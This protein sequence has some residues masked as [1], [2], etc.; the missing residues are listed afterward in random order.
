MSA[1]DRRACSGAS[2]SGPKS[3]YL[4]RG[5]SCI[6]T[7]FGL[8]IVG[9]RFQRLHLPETQLYRCRRAGRGR[10]TRVSHAATANGVFGT[11]RPLLGDAVGACL[12]RQVF[13]ECPGASRAA[14]AH[15]SL[16]RQ[17]ASARR[18]GLLPGDRCHDLP[19]IDHQAQ[20]ALRAAR[21]SPPPASASSETVPAG[22]ITASGKG[23]LGRVVGL[24]HRRAVE[25]LERTQG[26][27]Q[28]RHPCNG[29]DRSKIFRHRPRRFVAAGLD[30]R[31]SGT[32]I[33]NPCP[34]IVGGRNHRHTY[35]ASLKAKLAAAF[36]RASVA[37]S[38]QGMKAQPMV[39]V[40]DILKAGWLRHTG[41]KGE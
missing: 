1:S 8:S 22:A 16:A 30:R 24:P 26:V 9:A 7:K 13:V 21:R 3:K 41:R 5:T 29:P 6:D 37:G 15:R 17:I 36:P 10:P 33:P 28:S 35:S 23:S 14:A 38:S 18:A 20:T 27:V 32:R 4:F 19:I 40:R 2:A 31:S 12:L 25:R 11:C 39:E 34:P